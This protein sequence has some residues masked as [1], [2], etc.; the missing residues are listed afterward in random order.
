MGATDDML[1]KLEKKI[2]TQYTKAAK[3]AEKKVKA[4]LKDYNKQLKQYKKDFKVGKITKEQFDSWKISQAYQNKNMQDLADVLAQDALNSNK[5]AESLINGTLP[6]VYALNANA[7]MAQIDQTVSMG[8]AWTIYDKRTVENLITK[9][10]NLYP[11]AK[12]NIPK[13]QLW[14]KR[15]MNEAITQGVLQ[16]ESIPKISSRVGKVYNMNG[17]AST[18][19][20][21]TM[22]T[23]AQS[24]GRI[25][26]YKQAEKMGIP[27]TQMWLATLD[28]R[29]RHSHIYL[30]GQTRDV[31]QSFESLYGHIDY[32][33]DPHAD[34]RDVYNCRCTLIAQVKG[35]EYSVD[36]EKKRANKL[37]GKTYEE[38]KS[39]VVSTKFT[40]EQEKYLK[41]YGYTTT[42]MP[43]NFSE[44]S[45]KLDMD[46]AGEILQKMGTD[47]GDPHPYQVI[48]EYYNKN[49]VK[50][51]KV[52]KPLPKPPKKVK[53]T[54]GVPHYSEWIGM[55][56]KNTV[57]DMLEKEKEWMALIGDEGR[58]GLKMYTGSSYTEMNTYLRCLI[59]DRMSE[60]EA[61][62]ESGISK[63]QLEALRNARDGLNNVTLTEP[64]VVRRGSSLGDIAGAFMQGDYQEN[65]RILRAMTVDEMNDMFEGAIGKYASFTST[66][67]IWERGFNG[68]V[69]VVFYL[70]EG[71]HASSIMSISKFGTGEGETLLNMEQTARF[72]KAEKSDGHKRSDLRVFIEIIA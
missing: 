56:K 57:D 66:S 28:G 21:R 72:V 24:L 9:N 6:D 63:R 49:L 8:T 12:T 17:N 34:P 22:V 16:G 32:P 11:Q 26:S 25:D 67:S 68:E 64:L 47:W 15:K 70:P 52:K 50:P 62:A 39:Q 55:V 10:P 59:Q 5:I 61:I 7:T 13:S 35:F 60:A 33:A 45:H 38:W 41:P 3:E 43:K 18:R 58:T 53:T 1:Q 14:N 4:K 29:T 20:A 71:T 48:Q 46:V 42:S 40:P 27:L 65:K 23:S 2:K 44:W 54:N 51:T 30:D 19:V 36:D 69:E 31:G 37:D